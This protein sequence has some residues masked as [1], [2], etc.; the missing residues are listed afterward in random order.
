MAVISGRYGA[1][2]RILP[3][4]WDAAG[5]P[6]WPSPSGGYSEF[7]QD[8][9][10]RRSVNSDAVPEE[11]PA[12][13][14]ANGLANGSNQ[15]VSSVTSWS[16]ENTVNSVE[17]T[18]SNTRGYRGT[19]EGLHSCTGSFAGLG[20]CPP[21][22]PGQRFKFT[23]FV[24]PKNSTIDSEEGQV[25]QVAAVANSVQIAI[26][27]GMSNPITWTVQ[28]QS[29]Y[30]VPGDELQVSTSG[31]WDYS[32]PP[33]STMMPSNTKNLEIFKWDEENGI[34]VP[35]TN[36]IDSL[37]L[38]D[39]NVNFNTDISQFAN[40]CSAVAGGWQS[41]VV[42]ATSCEI[43][44][45]IH[46]DHY[47]IVR[48]ILYSENKRD[49]LPGVNH[50]I[51]LYVQGG[52]LPETSPGVIATTYE[53]NPKTLEL[54]NWDFDAM[55]FGTFGGLNVDMTSNN[56]LQFSCQMRYNAYPN[57]RQGYIRYTPPY[58]VVRDGS[59]DIVGYTQEP[60]DFVNMNP[61]A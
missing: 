32:I 10:G 16:M 9:S 45:N 52:A 29:D 58:E 31:F 4:S 41:C 26:N 48:D 37:C 56:P 57:G 5:K 47:S 33:V 28:W 42:G 46:G 25:Y 44:A 13:I 7:T 60:F 20:G 8:I 30:Q 35:F 50:R 24:G 23:G 12:T 49:H 6:Q 18:A 27:Y 61:L 38:L 19:L 53:E 54:A 22:A 21:I 43:T 11:N 40:S 59:G 55:F 51:K 17:Y 36:A 34:W 15:I 14:S 39:A 2:K 1:V 3:V